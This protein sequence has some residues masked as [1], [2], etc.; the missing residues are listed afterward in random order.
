MFIPKIRL[1]EFF[2]RSGYVLSSIAVIFYNFKQL[3]DFEPRIAL[4]VQC[5]RLA[6]ANFDHQF[7]GYFTDFCFDLNN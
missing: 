5:N 6:T 7:K 4:L 2:F 3:R 1:R